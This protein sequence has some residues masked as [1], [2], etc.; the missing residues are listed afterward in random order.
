MYVGNTSHGD[1][2]NVVKDPT[3][4]WVDTGVVDLVDI[5][6]F[7]VVV[8]TLPADSVEKDKQHEGAETGGTN[9]VHER[10]AEEEVFDNWSC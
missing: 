4:D 7:Q 8:T 6:L 9:P 5:G 2:G 1:E 3:D 10:V